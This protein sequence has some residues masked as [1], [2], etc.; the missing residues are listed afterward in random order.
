MKRNVFYLT[1]FMASGKSTVG[2]ILANALGWIFFDLDKEIEKKEEM[3]ITEIFEL[4]GENYF[5][6]IENELLKTLSKNNNAIISLGGGTVASE[7]NFNLIV[8]SGKIIYLKSSPEAAYKRLKYKRDRPA[9]LFEGDDLPTE[10]EFTD[11][12]NSLLEKRKKY[13]ERAD[14]I[15][16]TDHFPVG[17][18]VD[19]ISRIIEKQLASN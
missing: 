1:G 2:P 11:R 8:S 10:K 5:R 9:L 3:K 6:K 14:Y 12:I 17:K 4:K 15:I 16:D 18:T 7:E 19:K 13:Y